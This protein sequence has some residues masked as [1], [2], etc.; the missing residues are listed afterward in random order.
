MKTNRS[1]IVSISAIAVILIGIAVLFPVKEKQPVP[2][3]IIYLI[4]DGMGFGQ[5]STLI[6]EH[7][8]NGEEYAPSQL[9]RIQHMGLATTYSANSKVT[10][11]AAGGTAL[12]TGE[13]TNNGTVGLNPAGDTLISVMAEARDMGMSTGIVVN[14]VILDATPAAFYAH[15][16]KRSEGEM[17]AT[18]MLE[19]DYDLL[20]GD[21]LKYFNQRTD[22]LDLIED[23]TAKGYA[24]F[25]SPD[26]LSISQPEEKVLALADFKEVLPGTV[27]KALTWLSQKENPEGFF[28][29]IEEAR[30]DG[31]GHSN[32]VQGLM[33]EM[34]IMDQVLKVVLDYADAHQET[35]VIITADHETGGVNI[36]YDGCPYFSTTGHSGTV[37]PVFAYG[38]GAENFTELMDNTDIP[39]KLRSLM[40]R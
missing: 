12:A 40:A 34:E 17:I 19:S 29:M 24:F 36:G 38:P 35:L 27:D 3:N 9:N 5:V 37:V 11:S 22:S 21:G 2:K 4:G 8:V 1:V 26:E 23:F 10:D 30:I 15:V 39:E 31:H 20:I 14:T 13:K 16:P 32:N 7:A 33:D 28:L 18:Q 6:M 25:D